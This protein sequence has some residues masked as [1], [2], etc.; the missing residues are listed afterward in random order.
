MNKVS[1]KKSDFSL[2]R[3]DKSRIIIGYDLKKVT[4]KNMY[5]W[6][7]VYINKKEKSFISFKDVKDAIL[8]DI[9]AQTDEKIVNG[10]QWVVLHGEDESKTVT[11]WLSA[12]NQNNFKAF[13]DIASTTPQYA[14]WP[15]QYKIAEGEEE[16]PIYEHFQNIGELQQFYLGGVAYV[17]SCYTEGWQRKDAIDWAPYEALFPTPEPTPSE[18]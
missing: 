14:T 15:L 8:G 11:V 12:E 18:E 2:L 9:N 13:Y 17:N 5:E 4:G 7:E 16:R 1:G 3:E 10:Y 6:Y